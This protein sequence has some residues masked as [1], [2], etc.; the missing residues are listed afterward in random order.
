MTATIAAFNG[1]HA[2]LSNFHRHPFVWN[3]R[4]WQTAE[5]PYQ[6]YKTLD[7]AARGRIAVAPTPGAAKRAGR[8]V[9]L[10]ADWDAVKRQVM[11]SIL[12]AKFSVPELGRRLRATGD[13]ELVEGN[14]WGD[15]YWGVCRGDGRNELG[16]ILMRIR[17]RIGD[18]D[19][20]PRCAPDEAALLEGNREWLLAQCDRALAGH[21]ERTPCHV[22]AGGRP[23]TTSHPL[24]Q[25]TCHAF[26][27]LAR[28]A[29]AV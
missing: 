14:H 29:P 23:G 2:F 22:R 9:A 3:G 21:C 13:A 20:L 10:R 4:R 27:I 28:L 11:Q 6:A 25:P 5:H 18:Y 19:P 24:Q 8:A 26:E 16:R 1:A 12:V 17:G 15:T 7:A